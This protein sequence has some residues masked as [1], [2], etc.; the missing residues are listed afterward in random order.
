M[1]KE[2][3]LSIAD[4]LSAVKFREKFEQLYIKSKQTYPKSAKLV[5]KPAYDVVKDDEVIF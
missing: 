4:I 2:S 3:V 5:G 1:A